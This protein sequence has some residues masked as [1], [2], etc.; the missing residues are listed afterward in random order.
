MEKFTAAAYFKLM[1]IFLH[2]FVTARAY[3]LL[4]GNR[5]GLVS[6]EQTTCVYM[7]AIKATT[8]QRP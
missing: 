1:N 5:R 6:S 7:Q 4:L 3:K 2:C 8:R